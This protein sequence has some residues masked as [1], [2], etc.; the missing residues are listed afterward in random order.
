[1]SLFKIGDRVRLRDV[2]V[3][4]VVGG[5]R[6]LPVMKI[7]CGQVGTVCKMLGC[8]VEGIKLDNGRELPYFFADAWLVRV[9]EED[10]GVCLSVG[11]SVLV[12]DVPVGSC[13]D[14]G[15]FTESHRG[16]CGEMGEI[17]E[18]V[19]DLYRIDFYRSDVWGEGWYHKEWL[20]VVH[21]PR[22]SFPEHSVAAELALMPEGTLLWSSLAGECI[23]C[24]V[25]SSLFS[26]PIRCYSK[27]LHKYVSFT[28]FGVPCG[29]RFGS[30]DLWIKDSVPSCF[31]AEK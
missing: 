16:T 19:G 7:H 11:A 9:D 1:M 26:H 25:R 10:N 8:T 30:C 28:A 31:T 20:E 2:T 5:I 4:S 14:G 24:D 13:I 15:Y 22:C 21:L 23:L 27:Q 17:V 29:T 3:G 18:V 6:F 12:C